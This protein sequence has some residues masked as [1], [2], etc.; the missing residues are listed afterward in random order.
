MLTRQ[1][2][3]ILVAN[4]DGIWKGNLF[5]F[6]LNINNVNSVAFQAVKYLSKLRIQ[7]KSV[8]ANFILISLNNT[9]AYVFHSED[10]RD[11]IHKVYIG[12]ASQHN[13]SFIAGKPFMTLD[14]SNSSDAITLK[15]ILNEEDFMPVDLDEEC[16]LG[17]A[18][19]YYRENPKATKGDFLGDDTGQIRVLGEIRDPKHFKGLIRP[20]KEK[21]NAKFQYLISHKIAAGR[22]IQLKAIVFPQIASNKRIIWKS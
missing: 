11:D 14:Y 6:K 3:K 5:E 16:I 17:W 13:Q 10:Y 2:L 20:Y 8:P 9:K 1:M 15:G 18:E 12:A 19:R 7:G 4:T 22:R 21:I